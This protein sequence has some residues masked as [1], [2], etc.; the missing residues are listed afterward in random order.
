MPR[1]AGKVLHYSKNAARFRVTNPQRYPE[2]YS[3]FA[4]TVSCTGIENTV[5]RVMKDAGVPLSETDRTLQRLRSGSGLTE[6]RKRLMFTYL[7][8]FEKILSAAS[9]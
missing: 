7:C 9:P 3:A 2:R 6:S 8:Q 4:P 1:L 5:R